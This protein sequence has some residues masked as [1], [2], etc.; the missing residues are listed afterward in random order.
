MPFNNRG[1]F[2]IRLNFNGRKLNTPTIYWDAVVGSTAGGLLCLALRFWPRKEQQHPDEHPATE[3]IGPSSSLLIRLGAEQPGGHPTVRQPRDHHQ[4]AQLAQQRDAP[5][6]PDQQS[7]GH[8]ARAEATGE[9]GQLPAVQ[10]RVQ[11]RGQPQWRSD[12]GCAGKQ[13]EF[14][15]PTVLL[16]SLCTLPVVVVQPGDVVG[17]AAEMG[18]AHDRASGH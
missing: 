5:Q 12:A 2:L 18:A 16:R 10:L 3:D 15:Q 14:G 11:Y 7:D 4:L 6:L 1:C 17:G 8:Q 9:W 13:P